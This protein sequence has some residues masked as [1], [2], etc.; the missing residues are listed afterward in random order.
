MKTI[1]QKTTMAD[2]LRD[3]E[4]AVERLKAAGEPMLAMRISAV[5]R[6]LK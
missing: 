4:R 1:L 5:L 6:D 3:L 2:A